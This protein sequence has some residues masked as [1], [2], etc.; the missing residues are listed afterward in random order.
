[1]QF[2]ETSKMGGRHFIA[3][4]GRAV[5][6]GEDVGIVD[7]ISAL[8]KELGS[9][10]AILVGAGAGFSTAA[11]LTYA[12]R[13]FDENFA[14]FRD[15]FG[16]GDIYSG[17]FYPFPDLE[18]YWAWWSRHIW[19]NRYV[20]PP[21]NTFQKLLALLQGR[22]YFVITTNV[23][24]QFQRAGFDKERLFYTQ[25]DYGLFQCSRPCHDATY[26]NEDVVREMYERQRDMHVPS[27][28]LPT[29]PR[30]GAAMV[31]NLRID[32]TFVE[33]EGW[34]AAAERYAQFCRTHEHDRV[35][36]LELGVGTNTPVIIKY[37]FWNATAS[38][39][40]ATYACVNM[41]E[42]ITPATIAERSILV[43]ADIDGTLDQLSDLAD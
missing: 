24:H 12:G 26:D 43:D 5:V 27:E 19:V 41:G 37:P 13:R 39:G 14:D 16:I 40:R 42:A 25:G 32:G 1:M 30:C 22:D 6:F 23:D 33:D 8:R 11:G 2:W 20:D 17:G 4:S 3:R 7:A 21:G 35:L 10:D 28:L 38:N 36:Y 15:R 31:P 34:H 9:C 29:C 18:T